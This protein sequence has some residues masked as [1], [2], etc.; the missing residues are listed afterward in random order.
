M[1]EGG[2]QLGQL[3]AEQAGD[4]FGL[5]GEGVAGGGLD[6]AVDVFAQAVDLVEDPG[7][8]VRDGL[9][10]CRLGGAA[11]V[12][13]LVE[14]LGESFAQAL[15]P[16]QDGGVQHGHHLR[17]IGLPRHLSPKCCFK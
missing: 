13:G 6:S 9:G 14:A 15:V 10:S 5:A 1:V 2:A 11:G 8:S 4:L 12:V 3:G 7:E 16:V 17:D